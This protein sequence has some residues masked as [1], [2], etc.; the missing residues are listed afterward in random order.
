MYILN[1]LELAHRHMCWLWRIKWRRKIWIKC[2]GAVA[3]SICVL[4]AKQE[5]I[6]AE[7]SSYLRSLTTVKIP[8]SPQW[9]SL[10]SNL[11]SNT[12][13]LQTS[14][15][16]RIQGC[17][18]PKL[19]AWD[20]AVLPYV[21][22][23][24]TV[25]CS[26]SQASLLYTKMD[27]LYLNT[28][29]MREL[30]YD[31]S[32]VMCGYRYIELLDSDNYQ[33]LTE[34]FLSGDFVSLS[35][36][37]NSVW[38]RCLLSQWSWLD[39]SLGLP[40]SLLQWLGVEIYHNILLYMPRVKKVE[41]N[42]KKYSVVT[43]I[44]DGLS[45]LNLIRSLPMTVSYLDSLGGILFQ[46]QH[47]VGHN[48][49]PNVMALLSGENGGDWPADWPNRTS[50]Y[51]FDDHRQPML[52]SLYQRHGYVTMFLEDLQLF[53]TLNREGRVGFRNPPAM[54]YYRAAFWAMIKEEWGYL[55]NRLV[56]K[57][58][59]YACLQEKLLHIHQFQVLRDFIDTYHEEPSFAHLH[60]NEYLHNDLNMAKLY[61]KDLKE[62]LQHLVTTGS[63]NNT[64][65]MILGDHGFQRA[66]DPFILTEQGKVETN[67]P[68]LYLLP[69]AK[70]KTDKSELHNNLVNNAKK[71]T[72]FYD[73]NQ[74]LRDILALGVGKNSKDMFA[75]FEGH[76]AS[77]FSNLTDRTCEEAE[78]P[79]EYCSCRDGVVKLEPS[80]VKS[81]AVAILEDTD[82]F[83]SPLG[84]CE[85]LHLDQL[86][87]ATAK[88]TE[89]KISVTLQIGV[90]P[91]NALFEASFSYQQEE[92]KISNTRLTRLDWYSDTSHCVPDVYQYLRPYC[93]CL[94]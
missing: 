63:I 85:I 48:S 7:L 33:F 44:I 10:Q 47:R 28:T 86:K 19:D 37:Y 41:K 26:C 35:N 25:T 21:S 82:R 90:K 43:L 83:I 57:F 64:F 31:R 18:L 89:S 14:Q 16:A 51:Y 8:P 15:A 74:M 79:E 60:L 80:V 27:K 77:L 29:A 75:N 11:Q 91:H 56:G 3:I 45:Q 66:E 52:P 5:V 62:M 87:E 23:V 13:F 69:P 65:F 53:G 55:R 71:L 81:T 32:S 6:Q 49:Y 30:G 76:G 22:P 40:E 94:S 68:A 67:M 38:A 39:S 4:Y 70:F 92:Y 58:G 59:A 61:D 20:P 73:L 50:I 2:I 17:T 42:D 54:I 1:R 9:S 46:G 84:L 93:I 36:Q 78:I 12:P 72:S 24:P 34:L 88:I